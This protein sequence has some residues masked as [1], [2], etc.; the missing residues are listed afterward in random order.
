MAFGRLVDRR[1]S[2]GSPG[3]TAAASCGGFAVRGQSHPWP[4]CAR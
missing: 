4:S 2:R 1:R 3:S